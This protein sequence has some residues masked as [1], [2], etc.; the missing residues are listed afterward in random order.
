MCPASAM[1]GPHHVAQKSTRTSLPLSDSLLTVSP[2]VALNENCGVSPTF[3]AP[4]AGMAR[5][6][7]SATNTTTAYI[8]ER[9]MMDPLRKCV[10]VRTPKAS[11]RTPKASRKTTLFLAR[12]RPRQPSHIA[13]HFAAV[14]TTDAETANLTLIAGVRSA[15]PRRLRAA[16]DVDD[17]GLC[18]RAPA[19]AFA[20]AARAAAVGR[21]RFAERAA[22]GA[23]FFRQPHRIFN[24]LAL[25]RAVLPTPGRATL[26]AVERGAA[27]TVLC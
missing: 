16:A 15:L 14:A 19:A 27:T 12:E 10:W 2:F 17:A 11:F 25:G 3:T 4:R 18:I 6:N 24:R 23:F 26:L 13:Q 21:A 1:H 9:F 7:R 20:R 8:G 5:S 22:G